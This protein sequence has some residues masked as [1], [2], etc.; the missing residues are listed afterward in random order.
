MTKKKGFV[1][2]LLS[3]FQSSGPD[4]NMMLFLDQPEHDPFWKAANNLKGSDVLVSK[5]TINTRE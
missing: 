5:N 2:V 4:G 3:D 1:G